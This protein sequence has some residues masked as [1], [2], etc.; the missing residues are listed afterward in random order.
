M[1]HYTHII[2]PSFLPTMPPITTNYLPLDAHTSPDTAYTQDDYPYGYTL[3]TQ[4]RYWLE[5]K[6]KHGYRLMS[7]TLNPKTNLWN[8][9]KASTYSK[10]ARLYLNS[11]GHLHQ[12][13]REF[14]TLESIDRAQAQGFFQDHPHQDAI[15]QESLRLIIAWSRITWS[16]GTSKIEGAT[17]TPSELQASKDPTTPTATLRTIAE[18]LTQEKESK[19]Q[20]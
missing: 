15:L 12:D 14:Q 5:H 17:I 16:I 4:I 2:Y 9:P 6:P 20:I 19:K 7:Q 11:Q 1:P 13:C 8:K 18:R 10:Y 3:R